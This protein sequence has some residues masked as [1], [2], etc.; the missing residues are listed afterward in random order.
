VDRYLRA[1]LTAAGAAAALSALVGVVA[2]VGA[3]ALLFRA[4][5][6]G[7]VAG[8]ATYGVGRLLESFVPGLAGEEP[9]EGGIIDIVLPAEEPALSADAPSP[10]G[11]APRPAEEEAED[12]IELDADSL[13][14]PGARVEDAEPA[15]PANAGPG[16]DRR[17]SVGFDEL[18]VLPDLE[19][20]ADTFTA[21]E[22]ASG[23]GRSDVPEREDSYGGGPA[24]T[25]AGPGGLDPASL[26][27]AVRTILK[28]DQKG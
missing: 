19:G 27:Q 9:A 18:D 1:S 26:A 10:R 5:L 4:L 17:P 2:G 22:F 12:L 14:G 16:S 20:F 25:Q 23:G 13:V 3:L 28:R 7:A 21:S 15:I 24:R 6:F 11:Q 8:A